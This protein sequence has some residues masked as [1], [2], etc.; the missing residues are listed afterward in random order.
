MQ[1]AFLVIKRRHNESDCQNHGAEPLGKMPAKRPHV[2]ES[3]AVFHHHLEIAGHF[4]RGSP[5]FSNK[6]GVVNGWYGILDN[7]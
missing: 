3:A 7:Y 4:S 5:M 2:S 6:P 1:G